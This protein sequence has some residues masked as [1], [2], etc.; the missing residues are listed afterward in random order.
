MKGTIQDLEFMENEINFDYV[1]SN[2]LKL[3]IIISVVILAR[4]KEFAICS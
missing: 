1:I 2:L 4:K 3:Y